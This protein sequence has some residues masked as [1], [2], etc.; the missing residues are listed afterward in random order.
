MTL[1]IDK[2]ETLP[3][4]EAGGPPAAVTRG[5]ICIR[6]S[7]I[8]QFIPLSDQQTIILGRDAARC[9][10]L[11]KDNQVSRIHC[12]ITY[13]ASQEKY[14]VIDLSRNGTYLGNGM[15]LEQNKEYY[16]SHAEELYL[17]NEDNLYQLR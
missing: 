1:Q 10:H 9:T 16:L 17:G 13:L 6:G 14:C 11:I 7:H 12:K 2:A 4:T 5:L 3:V 15:R 8:G